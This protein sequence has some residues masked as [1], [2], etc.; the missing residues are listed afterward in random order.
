VLDS[1]SLLRFVLGWDRARL[2]VSRELALERKAERAFRA[3]LD[4]RCK[5]RPLQHLLGSQA[6]WHHEFVVNENVLIP[7]PE[8]EVLVEAALGRLREQPSPWI[9]DV[10]TGSGC[11]A[12]SLALGL[13][14]AT[15]HAI[16]ISS[17]A[18]AVARENARR[19]GVAERIVF[20][21]GDL[22]EPVKK[23]R[24]DLVASN[25]PYI[26]PSEIEDL[27]PEVRD[28]EPRVAL[29]APSDRLSVYRKLCPQAASVL[30]PGGL[31]AVEIG[32]G[33]RE[34]VRDVATSA[35]FEVEEI[36]TDLAGVPRVLVARY[37]PPARS[38]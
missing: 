27:D 3:L 12:L 38:H 28:F 4:E 25:P 14:A 17:N 31:L 7:R 18:L 1:E 23:L 21:E 15:T 30:R 8:T 34:G 5:R 32:A 35:G 29:V 9:V 37:R 10:G 2:L 33:M 19:L 24:F 13:K 6:F 16:D 26:D 11:I 22:L 20:H 36:L